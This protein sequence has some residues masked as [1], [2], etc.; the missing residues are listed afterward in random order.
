M[1][2]DLSTCPAGWTRF[3]KA[4]N[5]FIMGANA[6][7]GQVGG[8]SK[9]MMQW[10]QIAPHSHLFEDTIFLEGGHAGLHLS[11]GHNNGTIRRD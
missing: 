8:N 11:P 2:F 7:F 3:S 1:A 6:G 5:R 9:I 4:D 10:D